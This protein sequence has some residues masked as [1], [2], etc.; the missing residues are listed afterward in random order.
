MTI[1][2]RR[3][4]KLVEKGGVKSMGEAMIKA[5]YSKNT[6]ITPKKVTESKAWPELMEQYLPDDKLLSTHEK[7][8]DATKFDQFTGEILPD[9]ATR[10]RAV[11]LGYKIKGR[12]GENLTQVNVSNNEQTTYVIQVTNDNKEFDGLTSQSEQGVPVKDAE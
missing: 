6:A 10:L 9:H 12:I 5:G 2:Q 7:A 1:K 3:V 4:A 8:L 11:D